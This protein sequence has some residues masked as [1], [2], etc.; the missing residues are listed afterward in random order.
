MSLEF[1]FSAAAWTQST[2]TANTPPIAAII[3]FLSFMFR[4]L[5]LFFL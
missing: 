5:S 3:G 1:G 2:A 4:S